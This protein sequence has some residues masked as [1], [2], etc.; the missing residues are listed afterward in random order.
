MTYYHKSRELALAAG[1]P[2]EQYWTSRAELEPDNGWVLILQPKT[3]EVFNWAILPIL[4]T[5][6][7]DLSGCPR[8]RKRP[9][10]YRAAT[11]PERPKRPAPTSVAADTPPPTWQPGNKLPWE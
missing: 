7:I 6:E 11:P 9:P 2:Y 10:E 1:Q 3:T 5:A 8:L 4:E